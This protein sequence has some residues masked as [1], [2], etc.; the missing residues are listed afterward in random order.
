MFPNAISHLTLLA[1]VQQ[2]TYKCTLQ[3]YSVNKNKDLLKDPEMQT[4]N[5]RI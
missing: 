5:N 1:P 4:S 2:D 3:K